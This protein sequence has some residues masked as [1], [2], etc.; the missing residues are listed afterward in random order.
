MRLTSLP[1]HVYLGALSR[2]KLQSASDTV[3][4]P[5]EWV[6]EQCTCK[7]D[8]AT[9]A[10]QSSSGLS[11]IT[12]S[13]TCPEVTA[14]NKVDTAH[15]L[16]LYEPA[17]RELWGK[18]LV[19]WRYRSL[20]LPFALYCLS[21]CTQWCEHTRYAIPACSARFTPS[22]VPPLRHSTGGKCA[23]RESNPN[24]AE[25]SS[26]HAHVDRRRLHVRHLFGYLAWGR[27]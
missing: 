14:I 2:R 4:R 13:S 15:T 25:I 17:S 18:D 8:H 23:A 7:D 26:M 5:C 16:P 24:G 12:T 10:R 11:S 20:T 19:Y 21:V 27:S 1:S 3:L 9:F 22:S 6:Y